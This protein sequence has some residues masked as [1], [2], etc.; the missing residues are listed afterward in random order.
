ME[1]ITVKL[2]T[3]RTDALRIVQIWGERRLQ[4]FANTGVF[5]ISTASSDARDGEPETGAY[6]D[7]CLDSTTIEIDGSLG[8]GSHDYGGDPYNRYGCSALTSSL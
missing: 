8:V 6:K 7:D 2:P 4:G 5:S 1:A 3:G